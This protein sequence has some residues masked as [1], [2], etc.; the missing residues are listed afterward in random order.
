MSEQ[1]DQVT[2]IPWWLKNQPD[3]EA[4]WEAYCRATHAN[5]THTGLGLFEAGWVAALRH[6]Q[7]AADREDARRRQWML[8]KIGE[9]EVSAPA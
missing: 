9:W 1:H 4:I 7:E 6:L 3:A 2:E 8:D 5:R